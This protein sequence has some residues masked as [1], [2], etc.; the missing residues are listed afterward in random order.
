MLSLLEAE[1][2]D[3]VEKR[4]SECESILKFLESTTSSVIREKT[5]AVQEI[6]TRNSILLEGYL[7]NITYVCVIIQMMTYA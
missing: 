4:L 1:M 5:A 6:L 3:S 7:F 2:N